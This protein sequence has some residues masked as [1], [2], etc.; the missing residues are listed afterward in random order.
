MKVVLLILGIIAFLALVFAASG[1]DARSRTISDEFAHNR[2][3]L[4]SG[5][6]DVKI[7]S[8]TEE[9]RGFWKLQHMTYNLEIRGRS[10][11]GECEIRDSDHQPA[12]WIN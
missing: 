11:V 12:C 9:R 6:Y 1:C 5:V 3:V 4:I 2:F 10:E 7:V 8:S